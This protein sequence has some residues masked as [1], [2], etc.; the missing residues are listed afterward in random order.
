MDE[1]KRQ[2]GF[3]TNIMRNPTPRRFFLSFVEKHGAAG[4]PIAHRAVANHM[5]SGIRGNEHIGKTSACEKALCA[6]VA[7]RRC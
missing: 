1:R 3:D 5:G 7:R 4:A 2:I 6:R